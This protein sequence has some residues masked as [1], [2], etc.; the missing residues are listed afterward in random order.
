MSH[1]K[2]HAIIKRHAPGAFHSSKKKFH[3]RY[4]K[5]CILILSI[6]FAYFIFRNEM[7][8]SWISEFANLNIFFGAFV[9][10]LLIAFGF[11]SA[12]GI[13]LFLTL[14]DSNIFLLAFIGGLGAMISDMVIFKTIKISFK[15]E[16]N[17]IKKTSLIK[18]INLI[19]KSHKHALLRHYF[20]YAL[21]GIVIAAPLPD[22][23]GV[24]MLAGLTTI[25]AYLMILI[26]FIL[27]TLVIL[28]I[29]SLW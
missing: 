20:L 1:K 10:G 25:K 27:H 24:S 19:I 7:I 16:F 4:Y 3:F 15:D 2:I 5:I 23:I 28:L 13:G 14:P 22:E 17:E 8:Y 11:T 18:K 12:F 6:L 29:L 21:A 26:S 9:A